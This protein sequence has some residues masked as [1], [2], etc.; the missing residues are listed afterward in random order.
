MPSVTLS[1]IWSNTR[2]MDANGNPAAGFKIYSYVAGSSTV[3]QATYQDSAGSVPSSDPIVLDAGGLCTQEIWLIEGQLYNLVLKDS[4]DNVITGANNISGISRTSAAASFV[5][6]SITATQGQTAF[7]VPTYVPGTNSLLVSIN[8]ATQL[9]GVDYTE[10]NS[11]TITFATGLNLSDVVYV[12]ALSIY[13]FPATVLGAPLFLQ[14]TLR[15][16]LPTASAFTNA[17]IV[18][19]DAVGGRTIALSNGTNWISMITG[20]AV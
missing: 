6:T 19:T 2:F 20:S 8:G 18:V 13:T 5:T 10:T 16:T 14:A 12:V 15:T 4:G 17:A 9:I 1:P 3:Q 7:T 11:T